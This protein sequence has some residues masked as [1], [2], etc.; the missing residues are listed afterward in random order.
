MDERL[1]ALD[2][3]LRRQ[4]GLPPFS[5]VPASGDASFRR[6]FRVVRADGSCIAMDAPPPNEDCRPFVRMSRILRE[7]G[8]NAPEVR[9]ADLDRG[10]LLLDDLG[11]RHYLD[12]L[13]EDSV[14]RL[15]GDA[16]AALVVIQS[17]GPR[18]G[19]PPYDR[20]LLLREM[21]LFPQWLLRGLL[22]LEL[23]AA[24]QAMLERA[25][26]LLANSA[27]EQ[28]RV[29]VHRDYHARN[30][31]VTAAPSPGI[32]DFQD[33]LV[34]PVTYD[35]VSLLRDCYVAWPSDRV[36]NWALGYR[37]LALQSG[38]ASAPDED[39]F[40]RWFDLMGVQ[41]HLKASGIFARLQL[42]DGKSGYLADIPRTLGYVVELAPEYPELRGL[43]ELIG[44]R[45]LPGLERMGV[46]GEN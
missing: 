17:C 24:E 27:L 12:A 20:S 14:E 28:P 8:L 13:D 34:G 31:L 26:T 6:Y 25:F 23:S 43:V 41:R 4:P 1:F 46:R 32:L 35:L 15:Y 37:E 2:D 36:R 44:E 38:V 9:A 7:L 33:A 39:Q 16:L 3:W 29:C 22:D 40:L 19:L 21:G 30:L 11:D 18:A 45:V 10:F 5:M 42:R